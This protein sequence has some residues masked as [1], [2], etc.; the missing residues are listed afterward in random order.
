MV[1][2]WASRILIGVFA[3]VSAGGGALV[4][5]SALGVLPPA[6][7]TLDSAAFVAPLPQ[8]ATPE[9][10]LAEVD[11]A[12]QPDK[13][14]IT[15]GLGALGQQGVGK[16]SLCVMD[17]GGEVVESDSG[18]SARVPASSWKVITAL[19]A[20]AALGP[21]HRFATTVVSSSSGVVLV[22]G[23]DP[24]LGQLGVKDLADQTA[25]AL[26]AAGRTSIVLG[27]DDTLFS[28][29][30]WHP[31]WT[32][33]IFGDVPPIS[34]LSVD[35]SPGMNTTVSVGA[36]RALS[37]ELGSRGISVTGIRQERARAQG[38]ELAKVWS[39]PLS[40][41][42]HR[43]LE[44]SDNFA[45]EVL[46]RHISVASGG[47]GSFLGAQSA[48]AAYLKSR[49]LWSDG[50]RVSDGSGLSLDNKVSAC[51][52]ASAIQVA[53]ADA[54]SD[55]LVGLPV[56]GVSGTLV[57]R[58]DDPNEASGRGVVRAKTG[59]H[60]YVRTLT[61]FVQTSNGAILT[62]SFMVWDV[63]NPDATLNWIDQAAAILADA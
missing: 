16:T 30:S 25:E 61:G 14:R 44:I 6:P 43:A 57:N 32:D 2:R 60:D 55:V 56:A 17:L 18:D 3:A 58:F 47:D 13:A 20:L 62:F 15:A 10:G 52:L 41:I 36:A 39:V 27:Y 33:D 11:P 46:F 53:Y 40:V 12:K 23:G 63:T 9:A 26:K 28:G 48:L 50:M 38:E 37:V 35:P 8:P 5:T 42:V 24:Y 4:T 21:D 51:V 54:L 49:G 45:S 31:S 22:G 29:P 7:A 59:T 1:A 19:G 34:A